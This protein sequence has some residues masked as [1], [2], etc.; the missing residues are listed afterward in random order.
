MSQRFRIGS[1]LFS[2]V[3]LALV[4]SAC[5]GKDDVAPDDVEKQAFE[6]LR[7][8]I[9]DTIADSAREAEAIRLVTALE[10]DLEALRESVAERK[11]KARELNANYDTPRADFEA[12]L[13]KQTE[14]IKANRE[15]I[16]RTHQALLATITSEEREAID[17]ARTNAMS[18]AIASIQSI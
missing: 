3:C 14:E 9:R 7:E 8:Q 17:K 15:R 10:S 4:L 1:T 2:C 11:S 16:S 5:A 12:F 13:D 6:D 18:T